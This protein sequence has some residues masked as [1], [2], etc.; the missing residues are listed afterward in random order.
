[1]VNRA[2]IRELVETAILAL[3]IFLGLHFSVQNYQV[4][5]SSMKPTLDEGQYLFVNKLVYL[6]IESTPFGTLASGIK[7]DPPDQIFPFHAPERGE[8]VI[9]RFPRD[10]SRDFVKRIIAIP[11]DTVAIRNGHVYING[12]SLKEPYVNIMDRG[13]TGPLEVPPGSYF[14][15]GDNRRSSNDSRDWG[16][17][18]EENIIG[19]AWISY[20]PFDRFS[21]INTP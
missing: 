14:V 2:I 20:W 12:A 16:F 18:P 15:L 7:L 17:V 4:E 13:S 3:L 21:V 19:R 9:F 8:V 10:P 11:G 1:M 5:G 6:K